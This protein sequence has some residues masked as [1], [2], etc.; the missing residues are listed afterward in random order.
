MGVRCR[1]W[2]LCVSVCPCAQTVATGEVSL[3]G[4]VLGVGDIDIKAR[5]AARVCTSST[6][7]PPSS[8][9]ST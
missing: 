1:A 5:A 9:C 6:S 3:E 2:P 7:S 8:S 4:L